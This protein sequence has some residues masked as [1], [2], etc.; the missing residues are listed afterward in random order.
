V[1][2]FQVKIWFQNRRAKSKRIQEAEVEKIRMSQRPLLAAAAAASLTAGL[3][4]PGNFGFMSSASLAAALSHPFLES[5][6]PN[7]IS[8]ENFLISNPQMFDKF[9]PRYNRYELIRVLQSK[10]LGFLG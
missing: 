10:K 8:A 6:L 2:I 9:P 5:I 3:S 1:C 4:T 7:S